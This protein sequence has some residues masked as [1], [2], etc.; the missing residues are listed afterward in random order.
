MWA[1]VATC[2]DLSYTVNTLTQFQ[3]NPGPGYWK[4]L[5]HAYAYVRGTLDYAITY[6]RGS[7]ETLKP[8]RYVDA[9]YGGD[10]G[11]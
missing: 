2:P 6:Y 5:M 7:D 4:A 1:Q 11:T 8:V 10:S 9:N 3:T